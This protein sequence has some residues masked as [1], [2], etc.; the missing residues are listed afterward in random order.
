MMRSDPAS[1]PVFTLDRHT[2]AWCSAAVSAALLPLT[3]TLPAWLAGLVFA[4]AALGAGFGWRR[5]TLNPW[6]RLPLTLGVAGV[7]LYAYDF[8]FGRDTGAA[9]LVTM[10]ALKLFETRGVRDARSICSF[11]LFAVMAGFLQSQ[12]PLTL[13]L[14]IA[15]TLLLLCALARIAEVDQPPRDEAEAVAAEPDPGPRRRVMG[16]LRLAAISLP[17]AF[18]GFFLFPRLANPL[19]GLPANSNE[20]RTGL[21]DEMA[22]G[23][24][25]N[26]FVD[27]SPVAR[28]RFDGA[29]PAPADM[30]WRGPVL[31]FFNGRTWTRSNWGANLPPGN[32]EPLGPALEYEIT[33]EP[34]DRRY[35]LTLDVP[36]AAPMRASMGFDRMVWTRRPQTQMVSYRASSYTRYR[37]EPTLR[38]TYRDWSTELPSGFNPRTGALMAQWRAEGLEDAAIAQRALRLFNAEFTYSLSPPLLGRDSVDDFLFNT[39]EGYCEHFASAFVV[40]MRYAEIPARVVTGYQGGRSNDFGGYWV[41]RQSDAHA[42]AEIWLEGRGWVRIDPTSAVAPQRIERGSESLAGP[43][44]SWSRISRPLFDAGDWLRRNWNDVVLGFN[45]ARQ[46]S[47]LAPVGIADATTPQLGAALSIGVVIAL[48]L[49]MALLL[50]RPPDSADPLLR[51][52]RRFVA[53][54]ARAGANKRPDEGPLSFARRA[55]EVVPGAA[56]AVLAL[57]RRYAQRR[58]ARMESDP[59]AD[60]QLCDDLRRFRVPSRRRASNR[61]SA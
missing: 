36:A 19:W 28:I 48:L 40:M 8:R 20:A 54:L 21:S 38:H 37:F 45:A 30:Y 17:L 15:A 33:Q 14:A 26:L 27:E 3:H 39:K 43:E 35:L 31:V 9:L 2:L 58:Y 55:A 47:L 16:A 57:S 53:V 7:V 11:A 24:I 18:V 23:D 5:R 50:R 12:A 46:R 44:S 49:T 56:D 10:L 60:A 4:L 22:P 61:R 32:L 29:P 6:I 13:A 1:K 51:A 59:N 42:W 52:Y 41:V 34:T 25:A